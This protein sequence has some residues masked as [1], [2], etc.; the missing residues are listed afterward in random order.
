M[1]LTFQIKRQTS[2]RNNRIESD[3]WIFNSCDS[4]F[5]IAVLESKFRSLDSIEEELNICISS[6]GKASPIMLGLLSLWSTWSVLGVEGVLVASLAYEF[7][8]L[9]PSFTSMTGASIDL[10]LKRA[11]STQTKVLGWVSWEAVWDIV[12][13]VCL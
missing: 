2:L 6:I 13:F 5:G 8:G 10:E 4:S 9:S 12:W 11:E 3:N 7:G 1:S